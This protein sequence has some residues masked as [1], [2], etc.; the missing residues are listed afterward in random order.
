MKYKLLKHISKPVSRIVMGTMMLSSEREKESFNLLDDIFSL[1]IN[2]FDTAAVY[3]NESEAVLLKWIAERNIREEVVLLTKGGHHNKWRKR[4]TPYDILSDVND[5]LAKAKADY[6]DIF[7]LHRD[8][9]NIPVEPIVET[10]NRLYDMG[11]IRS[12]GG[13]NWS[14][15]RIEEANYYAEKYNLMGF[16]SVSP[17]YGL[18]EQIQDP[19]GE[20]C[21]TLTGD[22]SEKARDYYISNQLP[23]F[24]YSSLARGFFSG[25]IHA[26]DRSAATNFLDGAAQKGYL[27]DSNFERLRRAEVLAA[28]LGAT[29]PQIALA[30]LFHSPLNTFAIVGATTKEQMLDNIKSLDLN[31]TR[32]QVEWLNLQRNTLEEG[33]I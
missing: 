4:V 12:F 16:S 21:I 10:L 3:P 11:K 14:Y 28:Q 27:C 8:D 31:L 22:S 7:M 15:K 32:T 29:V 5:S 20:G 25:S 17:N 18:A 9:P 26:D 2:T 19:W 33:I 6:I 13:S 23:I 30:W 24:A 1:G